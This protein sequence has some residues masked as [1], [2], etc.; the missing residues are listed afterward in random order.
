MRW[1]D[2]ADRISLIVTEDFMM[3]RYLG[4]LAACL[5]VAG[6]LVAQQPAATLATRPTPAPASTQSVYPTTKAI[7]AQLPDQ[8][9]STIPSAPATAP[10]TAAPLKASP[11]TAGACTDPTHLTCGP[12][13]PCMQECGPAVCCLCGPPGRFWVSGEWLY[14]KSSG[15]NIPPLVSTA[16]AG[17]P[18]ATAGVLGNPSTTVLYGGEKINDEWRNGFRLNAGMWLDEC[19]R[20]GI[21]GN[22][23]FLQPNRE[24]YAIGSDGTQIITRPFFNALRGA[25]D[26][27]LVS[28]PG[29]LAGSV[30]VDSKTNFIGGGV[31]FVKNL[32]CD[33]CGRLDLLVGYRYLNLRDDIVI[34]ESLTALAGSNVA[35][36]TRFLIED[37]FKTN[38]DFHGPVVGL[39]WERRWSHW[40][41]GVRPSI[42]M[43]VTHSTVTIDGSTQIISPPPGSTVQ[44]FAGGLL[45]QP[46]NIGTYTSNSFSVIPEVNVRLGA[47]VT[48]HL[49]VFA[50]YN[51]LY[52]SNVARA[53]DQIDLRVNTNQIAPPKPL[54]GP[55]LP[56]FNLQ[57]TGYWV[58]GV[59]VGAELRF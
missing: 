58:Q 13:A 21:E 29:V 36:G 44:N 11:V 22:F 50:S 24:N 23:L 45:A 19:Q 27:Q 18:R 2:G 5:G 59:G 32:C 14:W 43:G 28:F 6:T 15:Q 9:P 47:Q 53:G 26:T 41:L 42:A 20:F 46:S 48:Q 7:K 56:A 1:S 49:R 10:A 16:P 31:N 54:N 4:G 30:S 55:A 8:L 37:R 34:R 12:T 33:P 51:Y 38:N 3:T 52:W 40:Y 39:N 17:T 25:N 35:P 57:R